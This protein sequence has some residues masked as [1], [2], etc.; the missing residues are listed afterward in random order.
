MPLHHRGTELI[1][2]ERL[3]LRRIEVSDAEVMFR[4][5]ASDPEVTRYLMWKPHDSVESTKQLLGIWERGYENPATYLWGI[6]YVPDHKLIGTI[7]LVDKGEISERA[8]IG[9]CIAR[10]YWGMGITTEALRA[11]VDFCFDSVGYHRLAILHNVTNP[12]SGRVAAKAGMVQEGILRGYTYDSTAPHVDCC[13]WSI[14][15]TDPRP[16]NNQQG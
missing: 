4:T 14:L 15:A 2:T 1:A 6:E 5:W 10:P 16:W 9:Y 3:L 12:A 13:V 7:S 11:V 8:D